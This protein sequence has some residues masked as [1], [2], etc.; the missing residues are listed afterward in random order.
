MK[1]KPLIIATIVIL[2]AITA[3]TLS[4]VFVSPRY[5]KRVIKT[6]DIESVSIICRSDNDE[7]SCASE[8]RS[9]TLS[10]EEI[11]A[12]IEK[13]NKSTYKVRFEENSDVS[14]FSCV[15]SYTDGTKIYFDGYTIQKYNSENEV[16]YSKKI[17]LKNGFIKD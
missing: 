15:L 10:D 11:S 3:L 4:L 12:F 17:Y 1:R 14:A 7:N 2:A 8:T 6:C 5:L 13:L 9:A 16:L